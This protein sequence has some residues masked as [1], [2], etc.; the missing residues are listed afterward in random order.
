MCR[1][2]NKNAKQDT[3]MWTTRKVSIGMSVMKGRQGKMWALFN[4]KWET[5]LPRTWRKL[6]YSAIFP[7]SPPSSTLVTP[8]TAGKGRD[9]ENEQP[10]V[11]EIRFKT[12]KGS[13]K[14]TSPWDL[15][16]APTGLGGAGG[17]SG[18]AAVHHIWEAVTVKLPLTRKRR[19]I[20][21]TFKKGKK[22]NSHSKNW[23]QEL[24]VHRETGGAWCSLHIG[25]G[26][27]TV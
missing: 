20:T 2:K 13:W 16:S 10:T 18:W 3:E 4:K 26:T 24:Y 8:I 19:N 7:Q 23:S 25:I 22:E 11:R 6:R 27:S 21:P 15:M 9:W 1:E 14:S 17:W 12:I 5:W